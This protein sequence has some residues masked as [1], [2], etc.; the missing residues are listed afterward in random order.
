VSS[1]N[2]VRNP[3]PTKNRTMKNFWEKLFAR[4]PNSARYIVAAAALLSLWPLL[5]TNATFKY[6]FTQGQT[7][8]YEDL[9]ANFDFAILKSP[10][11]IAKERAD[12]DRNVSPYYEIDLEAIAERKKLFVQRFEAQLKQS[13]LQFPDVAKNT[14]GYQNYGN[15]VIGRLLSKGILKIDTFLEKRDKEFVINILRGNVTEKQTF[16]NLLTPKKAQEWLSDSLPFAKLQEPEFLLPLLEPLLSPNLAFNAE[17]TREFKQQELEKMSTSRGMVKSGELIV[18]KG[19][20]I[21]QGVYQKLISFK[22]HYESDYL[23]SRKFY[24]VLFGYV[25]LLGIAL[26]LFLFYL[27]NNAK[28]AYDKL[29]WIVFLLGWMVIYSYLMYGVRAS[30]VLHP[31]IVPFCIAPIIIKNFYNRELAFVTH[32]ISVLIA[33]LITS[34]GYEFILLHTLAGLVVVFSRF[35]TRYWGNFYQSIASIIM[36]YMLGYIGISFIEESNLAL[37]DWTVLIWLGLNGFLTLLAYPLIPLFGNLF[38]FI[39]SITL[40][41]LSDLNHPLLKELSMKA[42]GTLQHSLQVANLS[43]AAAVSIGANDLLVK[44]GAL[45]HDVGKTLKPQYFIENQSGTN[46]HDSL[47]PLE[48]ATV[49]MAHVTEGVKMATKFGLPQPIIRFIE[50]HHGTTAVEFFYRKHLDNLKLNTSLRGT[51]QKNEELNVLDSNADLINKNVELN[52]VNNEISN[53][54]K[55]LNV[56]NSNADLINKNNELNAVSN[57]L[58][59]QSDESN[60][61][62]NELSN[63]KN[64][65]NSINSNANLINKN[66][67]LNVVNSE[68]SN[69]NNELKIKNE[70]LNAVNV[71]ANLINKNKE[72]NAVSN[73]LKPNL[74]I[75]VIDF[76]AAERTKFVYNGPKPTTREETILMLAD[77]LEAAAK[78]MKMPTSESIDNLVTNIIDSKI[79]QGQLEQSALT[80]NELERCKA[81]F[82]KTLKS[83]HHVRIEYP[84]AKT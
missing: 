24:L 14:E 35:D 83:I 13:R 79:K 70:E 23:A 61:I 18:P 21:T 1:A 67:E 28:T 20:I 74:D 80:F 3:I 9:M 42:P 64:E 49:I 81:S 16:Q 46:A 65:V 38:G 2:S 82:K 17:K 5:P 48:S 27:K 55:E 56:L 30:E 66:V 72:L 33:G 8:L 73:E 26:S 25:L 12:L 10:E 53:E 52:V 15:Y 76:E 58:I 29:R 78:S 43:E 62:N 59:N 75:T 31:Y 60:V 54:N 6:K 77:S 39:S 84:S 45:Y 44:V 34:P 57:K 22:D 63:N 37:I 32:M 68:L 7:W 19:G 51:K 11:E 4:I 36:V 47:S 69:N 40:A 41:E 71:N 50:T